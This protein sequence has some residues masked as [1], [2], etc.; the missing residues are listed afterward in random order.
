M[1]QGLRQGC[2]LAPLLFNIFFAVVINVAS[3]RFNADN[4]I[5][6]PLV[7]LRKKREL[8]GR[9]EATVGESVFA[10]P[11]WGMLYADDVGV[12]SQSPEQLRKMMGVVVVVCAVFGLTVLEAKTKITSLRTK[13]MPEST[14]TFSVEA[15]G[16]VYN[17]TN[18]FVLLGGNVNH[19]ADLSIEVDRSTPTS[20]RL[21]PRMKG[22]GA[23]WQ[24]K[25]RNISWRNGS[26]QRK[27][28]LN[29][30]MLW[31]ART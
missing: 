14:A 29:Y 15:A 3:T 9:G 6:D 8:G 7:Y 18:E 23:K 1:E 21:Q 25:R 28:R 4:T 31:Y 19:N 2:V 17:E 20:K 22:N 16:Q 27:P 30:G 5:M 10:T 11:L 13:G 26:L 12:V 24:N